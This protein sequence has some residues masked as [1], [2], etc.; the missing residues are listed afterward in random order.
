MEYGFDTHA[1]NAINLETHGLSF[2][3]VEYFDWSSALILRD[4]RRDY[5]EK[6]MVA[7]GYYGDRLTV[8]VYVAR[9][10][11]IRVISWR[12]ANKREVKYYAEN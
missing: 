11:T 2:L 8:L 3:D 9:G 4:D 12:K 7:I 6:R 5:G 1:K 10:N